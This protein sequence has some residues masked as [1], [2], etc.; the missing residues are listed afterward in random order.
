MFFIKR[1][2]TVLC[3]ALIVTLSF[4]QHTKAETYKYSAK[5]IKCIQNMAYYEARSESNE[6]VIATIFVVLNRVKD[7]RFANTPCS[8]VYQ[9][10]QFSFVG[11]EYPITEK[12]RYIELRHLVR[13]VL[14]GKYLDNTGQAL[15][16]NSTGKTPTGAKCT[17]KIGKHYFYTK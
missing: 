2:K 3:A 7:S 15:F 16:F 4:L 10:N 6:G 1:F 17:A 11:K 12:A 13:D 14:R 9:A 5:E 8:V